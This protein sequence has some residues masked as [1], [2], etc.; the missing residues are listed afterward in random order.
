MADVD[1]PM[2]RVSRR[3]MLLG[4]LLAAGG[5]AALVGRAGAQDHA[6]HATGEVA[7]E[8]GSAGGGL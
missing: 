7:G 1:V 4:G 8:H 2:E 5:A 3:G 6:H